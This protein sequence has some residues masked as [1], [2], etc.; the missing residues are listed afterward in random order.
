[1]DALHEISNQSWIKL[2]EINWITAPV[3]ATRKYAI[4][5]LALN[6]LFFF[7]G[8]TGVIFSKNSDFNKPQY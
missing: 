2:L 8:A 7:I 4:K 3:P 1:M 5:S 6:I